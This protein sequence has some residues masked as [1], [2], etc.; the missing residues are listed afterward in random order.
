[1]LL[2]DCLRMV[3][4]RVKVLCSYH[5]M[6]S[7]VLR[8]EGDSYEPITLVV[9]QVKKLEMEMRSINVIYYYNQRFAFNNLNYSYFAHQ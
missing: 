9:E 1:M 3:S 8:G 4:F 7:F 2:Y 5:P 6:G